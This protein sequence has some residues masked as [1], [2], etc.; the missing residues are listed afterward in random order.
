MILVHLCYLWINWPVQLGLLENCF[1]DDGSFQNI[2]LLLAES[3]LP[4]R[5]YG[6]TYGLLPVLLQ[7]FWF[8]LFGRDPF[9]YFLL[10]ELLGLLYIFLVAR[11]LA[12]Q[13]EVSRTLVILALFLSPTLLAVSQVTI[14]HAIVQLA[15]LG[16]VSLALD[17]RMRLA[18]L[19]LVPGM[20][21]IPTLPYV[22]ALLLVVWFHEW[23]RSPR[24]EGLRLKPLVQAVFP[25]LIAGAVAFG[26]ACVYFS[27][28]IAVSSLVPAKGAAMYKAMNFGFFKDGRYFWNPPGANI[29]YYL[30]QSA[31]IWIVAT[32]LLTALVVRLYLRPKSEV[33]SQRTS[34]TVAKYALAFHL[35]FIFFA[36]G[37]AHSH[38]YYN[39]ILAIGLLA[40]LQISPGGVRLSGAL[41]LGLLSLPPA[42]L[43]FVQSWKSN[44]TKLIT[45]ATRGLYATPAEADLW[46]R[47]LGLASEH[48]VFVLAYGNGVR[49]KFP[50]I[51]ASKG[52]FLL[53]G[54]LTDREMEYLHSSLL[55][56]RYVVIPKV[57]SLL[58]VNTDDR[59]QAELRKFRKIASAGRIDLFERATAN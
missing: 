38:I 34:V 52:W 50:E 51:D 20:F 3:L 54:L 31:G 59:V 58:F 44:H 32:I 30:G 47:I 36:F 53:P 43:F 21:S 55:R 19:F 24:A 7:R 39:C 10:K 18:F 22:G 49:I 56:S 37:N 46:S 33:E 1:T 15:L 11:I 41:L 16:S 48:R 2:D 57:G 23:T 4:V 25:A 35:I 45:E 14:A 12:V 9:S 13:V 29:K 17:G 40:A 5:D 28:S 6:Y 42:Y 8:F 27:P 26:I